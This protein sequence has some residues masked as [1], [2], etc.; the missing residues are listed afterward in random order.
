M[1]SLQSAILFLTMRWKDSGNRIGLCQSPKFN[2]SRI[3]VHFPSYLENIWRRLSSS[4][5]SSPELHLPIARSPIFEIVLSGNWYGYDCISSAMYLVRFCFSRHCISNHR[6]PDPF[7]SFPTSTTRLTPEENKK[8]AEIIHLHLY[9]CWYKGGRICDRACT[10][11][12]RMLQQNEID[13]SCDS[14]C[15]PC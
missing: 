5:F 15:D 9:M 11:E 10:R 8:A 3:H 2:L 4:N 13:L 7:R 6:N 12:C 14:F 1:Q